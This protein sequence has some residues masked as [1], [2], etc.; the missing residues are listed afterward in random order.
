MTNEEIRN[1]VIKE[2]EAHYGLTN[3]QAKVIYWVVRL[4]RNGGTTW[5]MLI[6]E[7]DVETCSDECDQLEDM[8]EEVLV[9]EHKLIKFDDWITPKAS[10][11]KTVL[12]LVKKV[13]Q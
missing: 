3:E 10:T 13:V 6:N 12:G 5:C 9:K 4:G 2:I 8:I 11:T 1:A 7:L